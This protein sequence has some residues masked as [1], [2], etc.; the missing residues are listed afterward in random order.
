MKKSTW[1]FTIGLALIA[2]PLMLL[3][4]DEGPVDD[5]PRPPRKDMKSPEHPGPDGG[6]VGMR[7]GGGQKAR[8]WRRKPITPEQEK[9]ILDFTEKYM[10][11]RHERLLRLRE[12]NEQA[13]RRTLVAL[14]PRVRRMMSMPPEMRQVYLE[15]RQLRVKIFQTART[16]HKAT[17]P[18]EKEQQEQELQKLVA[19][20]F[21]VEQKVREYRL[22]ELENHLLRLKKQLAQRTEERNKI[23]EDRVKRHLTKRE[24]LPRLKAKAPSPPKG[25][26]K[27]TPPR[28]EEPPKAQK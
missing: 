4:A 10:K 12:E 1:I 24:S 6:P 20:K 17:S 11:H 21:D 14:W 16:Y 22:R 27:D 19:R 9:Q 26:S 23:I 25:K 13:Y 3:G 8:R 15:E 5:K 2:A 18:E 28:P 7:P